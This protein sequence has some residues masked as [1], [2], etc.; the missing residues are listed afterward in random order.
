[1]WCYIVIVASGGL[2]VALIGLVIIALKPMW[3]VGS[4]MIVGGR[5]LYAVHAG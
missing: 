4:F 3:V 1:M 5:C 2:R